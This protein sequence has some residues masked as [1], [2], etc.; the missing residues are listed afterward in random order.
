MGALVDVAR[1]VL[2]VLVRTVETF[3][4]TRLL[5]VLRH[6]QAAFDDRGATGDQFGLELVDEVVPLLPLRARDEVVHPD[7]QDIFV[8]RPVEDPNPSRGWEGL[9]DA[10]Q[11]VVL[12]FLRG[13]LAEALDAQPL[14]VD[15][16][17]HVPDDAALAG[18]VHTL[19]N[20]Q[21]RAV[22]TGATVGVQQLLEVGKILSAR[23][24]ELGTGLLVAVES[25]R[26]LRV[27]G[28]D[29]SDRARAQGLGGGSEPAFAHDTSSRD[30]ARSTTSASVCG[31]NSGPP[32]NALRC[33]SGGVPSLLTIP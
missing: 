22:V 17:T 31:G 24:E 20:Q 32:P 5:L 9:V 7:G 3:G 12:Q 29:R 8:V 21:N 1:V 2:P 25:R 4:E 27:E 15:E 19:Q 10:P 26:R 13:R 33:E 18:R 28:G 11:E 16:T 6:H 30:S 14:W 23:G